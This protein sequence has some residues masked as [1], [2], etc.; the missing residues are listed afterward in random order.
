ME[1]SNT[2]KQALAKI[3]KSVL[4]TLS[5][6]LNYP[7]DASFHT[8]GIVESLDFQSIDI[9]NDFY[10]LYESLHLLPNSGQAEEMQADSIDEQD[11]VAANRQ[12]SST[13]VLELGD[14]E[15]KEKQRIS[16]IQEQQLSSNNKITN[17]GEQID[18]KEE[19]LFAGRN[20]QLKTNTSTLQERSEKKSSTENQFTEEKAEKREPYNKD[21]YGQER[22]TA[23]GG[24][25]DL[26]NAFSKEHM[27]GKA[28]ETLADSTSEP[29]QDLIAENRQIHNATALDFR[30]E[31]P[32]D[33]QSTSDISE[34]QLSS[35]NTTINTGEQIDRKEENP[36]AERNSQLKTNTNTH[37]EHT[38][39]KN[40]EGN[41]LNTAKKT[42]KREPYNKDLY[43]QEGKTTV[44]SFGD[45][46]KVF[47]REHLN[48]ESKRTEVLT[49]QTSLEE[50]GDFAEEYKRTKSIDGIE[51]LTKTSS[52]EST[53][54]ENEKTLAQQS[55]QKATSIDDFV[56]LTRVFSEENVTIESKE[57]IQQIEKEI[58]ST[59]EQNN[60]PQ[61]IDNSDYSSIVL[62]QEM[63][64]NS[65]LKNPNRRDFFPE[66]NTNNKKES[67]DSDIAKKND[68]S[69]DYQINTSKKTTVRGFGDLAEVISKNDDAFSI[70]NQEK[71]KEYNRHNLKQN[72][73]QPESRNPNYTTHQQVNGILKENQ[74]L[75]Q[76]SVAI[77][78][79][80]EQPTLVEP[81]K[82][83]IL[84]KVIKEVGREEIVELI[85]LIKEEVIEENVQ[86]KIQKQKR[87]NLNDTYLGNLEQTQGAV[88][89]AI[90]VFQQLEKEV[91]V[92]EPAIPFVER[93]SRKAQLNEEFHKNRK[94]LQADYRRFYGE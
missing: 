4:D 37:Q 92:V 73:L 71:S 83:S 84:D 8:S 41:Q 15:H 76:G 52:T 36:F 53:T 5:E 14:E 11:F 45:L 70:T 48:E 62:K 86:N 93:S 17:T 23:V 94:A 44:G 40:S 90:P 82:H 46:A 43:E 22:K 50:E 13:T 28:E 54:L 77:H 6:I 9:S 38:E 75:N 18:G 87:T 29:V 55:S 12:A 85:Q 10:S 49:N 78:K 30:D 42:E 25:G 65:S 64:S 88:Y 63:D 59:T 51:D 21:L 16:D 89:E 60:F 69:F 32:K 79:E 24:F 80:Q 27:S 72:Q 67:I 91:T 33:K 26:T 31:S 58:S 20:N 68:I 57:E 34:Q 1:L 61:E 39:K 56:D 66:N 19:K 3:G 2:S 47:S 81:K 74:D 35:S 7:V